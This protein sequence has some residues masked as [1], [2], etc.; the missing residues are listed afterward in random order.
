MACSC[1]EIS[2]G[3]TLCWAVRN[4]KNTVSVLFRECS[5]HPPDHRASLDIGNHKTNKT[6][7]WIE[8]FDGASNA[9]FSL[10]FCD[11]IKVPDS[12]RVTGKPE[13]VP[14]Q[15]SA[16]ETSVITD[17]RPPAKPMDLETRQSIDRSPIAEK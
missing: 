13:L 1:S 8:S 7:L 16:S 17:R 2:S 15:K 14:G 9:C 10:G 4:V 5:V 6:D 3:E 11:W 12:G